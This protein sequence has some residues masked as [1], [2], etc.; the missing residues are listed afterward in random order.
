[1]SIASSAVNEQDYHAKP[2]IS[3][4]SVIFDKYVNGKVV[5]KFV[6]SCLMMRRDSWVV[7]KSAGFVF[8]QIIK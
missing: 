5:S 8:R 6:K 1:M 4:L 2:Y 7:I 3:W